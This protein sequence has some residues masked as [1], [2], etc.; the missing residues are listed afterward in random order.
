MEGNIQQ[1]KGTEV[2]K[3]RTSNAGKDTGVGFQVVLCIYRLT[4]R[5]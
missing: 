5:L 2:G 3:K 4:N 1:Q